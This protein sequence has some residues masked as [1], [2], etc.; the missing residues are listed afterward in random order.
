MG[1]TQSTPK[2]TETVEQIT[3]PNTTENQ[4]VMETTTATEILKAETVNDTI[5]AAAHVPV[6]EVPITTG[7]E[8]FERYVEEPGTKVEVAP[9]EVA[10][11]DDVVKKAKKHKN[12]QKNK[13]KKD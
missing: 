2:P 1:T 9:V 10:P 11:S 3:K 12:K 7:S 4:P 5:T 13:N 8:V 6:E